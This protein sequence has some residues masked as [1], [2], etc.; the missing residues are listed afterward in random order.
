MTDLWTLTRGEGPVIV[1]VPHAG[2]V[3]PAAISSRLTEAAHQ[4]PDADWH[5]EK[6]YRSV[7]AGFSATLMCATHSRIVVDLNR[8][9]AGGALYPGASNTEICPLTTFHDEPIY[10]RDANPDA[11]E[12]GTRVDE[13][14]R[15]YHARL[16]LEI[17][18]IKAHYGYCI[19]L[20]GHSIVSV[21][22]RFFPGKLPDLNLGTAD[23][24]SCDAELAAAA[25]AVLASARG[26]S[27]V[28]NGRFKGGYITRRYGQPADAVHA[29]QLE[30]AQSCYMDENDPGEYHVT[31]AAP[32]IGVLQSLVQ[33]L[34]VWQPAPRG[35]KFSETAEK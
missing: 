3:I 28:H 21:A 27:A 7:A 24:A 33:C 32:L 4:N 20:D 22:P 26:F 5:V 9:C 16:D 19:L 10:A 18:R 8:D 2:T 1:N 35:S 13:Y 6:L 34:T 29:L 11:T 15:P 31:R 25:F 30:M 17:E 14:W 12:I 23:G